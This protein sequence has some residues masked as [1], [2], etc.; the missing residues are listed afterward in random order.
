MEIKNHRGSNA[1][2]KERGNRSHAPLG[3]VGGR[4]LDPGKTDMD[5]GEQISISII[6]SNEASKDRFGDI[7]HLSQGDKMAFP[8]PGNPP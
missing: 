7:R 3:F 1:V 6:I 5:A 8:G 4:H 2:R